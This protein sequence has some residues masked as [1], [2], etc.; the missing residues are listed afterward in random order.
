MKGTNAN[1]DPQTDDG[2]ASLLDLIRHAIAGRG[3]RLVWKR[4]KEQHPE[5]E[6][7]TDS[8]SK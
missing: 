4:L 1:P 3:E 2:R 6:A 7:L 8:V 5:L